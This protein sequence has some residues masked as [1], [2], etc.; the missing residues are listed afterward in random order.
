MG[1]HG[2]P[3]LSGVWLIAA[4]HASRL[5]LQVGVQPRPARCRSVLLRVVLSRQRG[6]RL[7]VGRVRRQVLADRGAALVELATQGPT[8]RGAG[9]LDVFEREGLAGVLGADRPAQ[10]PVAVENPDLAEVARS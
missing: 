10:E 2:V 4:V 8:V 5:V 9:R 1:R 6:G 3:V 7:R